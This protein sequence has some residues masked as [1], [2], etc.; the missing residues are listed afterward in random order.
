[1]FDL[2]TQPYA[3]NWQPMPGGDPGRPKPNLIYAD[4]LKDEV[5]PS[6]RPN[7]VEYNSHYRAKGFYDN[8]DVVNAFVVANHKAAQVYLYPLV[9]PKDSVDCREAQ[10]FNSTGF[11]NFKYGNTI[12]DVDPQWTNQ[13]MPP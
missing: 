11:P 13:D 9:W 4:T 2:Q 7:F 1:M 12:T 3:N 8:I 10:M 5:L 6:V